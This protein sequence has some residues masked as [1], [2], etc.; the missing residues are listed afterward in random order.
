MSKKSYLMSLLTTM[1]VAMLSVGFVSCG[2][3][4][5]ED[6]GSMNGDELVTK[7]QGKW[8]FYGG[9]ETVMGTTITMDK[10]TLNEIK[11]M[12]SSATGQRVYF[13]DETLDFNSYQVNGIKYSLKG[14]QLIMDGMEL[15][16]GFT[17]SIKTINSTTLILH[18]VISME[19]I[20][21]V[22][23]IEYH[24]ESTNNTENNNPDEHSGNGNTTESTEYIA[25]EQVKTIT[26]KMISY[27]EMNSNSVSSEECLVHKDFYYK[28]TLCVVKGIYSSA[29]AICIN[30]YHGQGDGWTRQNHCSVIRDYGSVSS[31]KD[32]IDKTS[33]KFD[34]IY[35]Y[36][37]YDG[38][39]NYYGSHTPF[40]PR[41]GYEVAFYTGSSN[42]FKWLRV[43]VKNYTMDSN[44][45]LTSVTL[46]YQLY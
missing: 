5:D 4:D 15:F 9:K 12:M 19:G 33:F 26:I 20:D 44:D 25:T 6:N 28:H 18:E 21:I 3:D 27:N 10:S 2:G 17:I 38:N 22:A 16:E 41:H 42:D 34:D 40:N 29:V 8:E 11:S 32:I 7:L 45:V 35:S 36:S 13:W 24:K 30:S 23:D 46:E 14:N 37:F 1:M 31:I 43:F 39:G